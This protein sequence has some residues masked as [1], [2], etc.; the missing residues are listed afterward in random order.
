MDFSLCH[1]SELGFVCNE[2]CY[3]NPF[4]EC[5][6]EKWMWLPLDAE[7]AAT[8]GIPSRIN[9][10]SSCMCERISVCVCM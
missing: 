2:A 6:S 5:P 9:L 10:Y 7:A 1:Y 4:I 8:F 3:R